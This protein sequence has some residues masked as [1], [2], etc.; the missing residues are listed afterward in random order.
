MLAFYLA[1]LEDEAESSRFEQLY[2]LHR[3]AMLRAAENILKD[4]SLAEDAVHEAFLRIISHMDK[5]IEINCNKTRAFVVIVV[6][7]ISIDML[8]SQKRHPESDI[9]EWEDLPD[10]RGN[11]PEQ[12]LLDTESSDAFSQAI[13]NLK[14]PYADILALSV[15]Y[16]M[17]DKEI[18]GFLGITENNVRVRLHRGR[19]ELVRQLMEGTK[20]DG[21]QR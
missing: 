5:I 14:K 11:N 4:Y 12:I 9:M 13:A 1:M 18:A 21:T 19:Q 6:K 16:E 17:S 10:S 3:F 15:A 8:R 2:L 7:N 20:K